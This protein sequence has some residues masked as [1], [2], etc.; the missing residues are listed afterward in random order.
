M[1]TFYKKPKSN[2]QKFD[3]SSISSPYTVKTKIVYN[4]STAPK[5][6]LDRNPNAFE[7]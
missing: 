1:E 5:S 4:R 3:L 2:A 6:R 7:R